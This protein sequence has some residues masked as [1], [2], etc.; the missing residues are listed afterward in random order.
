MSLK[1]RHFP[2]TLVLFF[3]IIKTAIK[4][5]KPAWLAVWHWCQRMMKYGN[6]VLKSTHTC[7]RKSIKVLTKLL[8][9]Y[10]VPR[11]LL[12]NWTW[13]NKMPVSQ[14][15]KWD[16]VIETIR[17]EPNTVKPYVNKS[18]ANGQNWE[19]KWYFPLLFWV[20]WKEYIFLSLTV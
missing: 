16:N 7:E 4:K 1:I 11:F 14:W 3:F 6:L 2:P 12:N 8:H 18:L 19:R 15:Y 9:F 5:N 17:T 20:W 13:L 10:S